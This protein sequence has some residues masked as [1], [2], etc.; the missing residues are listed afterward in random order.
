MRDDRVDAAVVERISGVQGRHGRI[1]SIASHRLI[2]N[3]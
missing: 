3:E 1:G 2:E